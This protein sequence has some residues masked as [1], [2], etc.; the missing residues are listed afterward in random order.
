VFSSRARASKPIHSNAQIAIMF[1]SK[2]AS[3][4][5]L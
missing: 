4:L 1:L 5:T 2:R 3:P